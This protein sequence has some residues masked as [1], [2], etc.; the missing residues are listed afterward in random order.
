MVEIDYYSKYIKY[1]QKYIELKNLLLGGVPPTP[2]SGDS[3]KGRIAKVETPNPIEK[4]HKIPKESRV[5]QILL[6]NI[7]TFKKNFDDNDKKITYVLSLST[8]NQLEYFKRRIN[9]ESYQKIKKELENAF[10]QLQTKGV[11][12]R[13]EYDNLIRISQKVESINSNTNR[14]IPELKL[15]FIG[16]YY[17]YGTPLPSEIFTLSEISDIISPVTPRASVTGSFADLSPSA[18]ISSS[19]ATSPSAA[20]ATSPGVVYTPLQ[21]FEGHEGSATTRAGNFNTLLENK[22]TVEAIINAFLM[23]TNFFC[24]LVESTDVRTE[25]PQLFYNIMPRANQDGIK[26]TAEECRKYNYLHLTFHN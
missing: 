26:K 18:A 24:Q 7:S 4:E 10:L 13:A 17:A 21:K 20:A 23:K 8:N 19:A 5:I 2:K 12:I 15:Y 11:F 22:R 14:L 6:A 25:L 16:L 1:K 9:L 3:P